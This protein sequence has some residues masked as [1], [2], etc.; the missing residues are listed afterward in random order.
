MDVIQIIALCAV[1]ITVGA[2]CMHAHN[3]AVARAVAYE[4]Q[5]AE[6]REERLRSERD[7]YM[8]LHQQATATIHKMQVAEA[9][10]AGYEDGYRAA[11]KDLESEEISASVNNAICNGL[12]E[13][14]AVSL[15]ILNH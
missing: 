13:G 9:N 2:T 15:R 7:N 12:R 3:F 14:G 5:R 4:R 1:L 10:S 6:K 11:Y 8:R